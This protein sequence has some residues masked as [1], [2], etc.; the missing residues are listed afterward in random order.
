MATINGISPMALEQFF[1][2]PNG[3]EFVNHGGSQCVALANFYH[4]GVIGGEF[5]PV[6]SAFQWWTEFNSYQTLP[7]NYVQVADTPQAGDI[8]IGR[9]GPYQAENGHIGVVASSWNGQ[10]FG[11]MEQGVWNGY[12]GYMTRLNRGMDNIL[13]FLRPKQ[14]ITP[15]PVEDEMA[16]SQYFIASS[17]NASGTVKAG[18]V[19]TRGFP[20]APLTALTA[21]QAHDWFALQMLDYNAR[22]V[23]SKEGSWFDLAFA[24]DNDAA[25]LT[26]KVHG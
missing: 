21:G 3:T 22:N 14:N 17:D 16:N 15:N 19:W 2:I 24:E 7:A 4:E 25:A 20:G 13:G 23:Y 1:A 6:A 18:D 12:N 5:V 9:Y 11:T 26:K 8:F 10:T